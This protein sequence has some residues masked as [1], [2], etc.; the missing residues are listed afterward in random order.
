MLEWERCGDLQCTTAVA[1]LDWSDPGSG[2]IELALVRQAARGERLGSLL[3]NPGG[4][5]GRASTSSPTRSTSRPAIGSS[6]A[7]TWSGSTRAASAG[8]AR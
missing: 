1:P 3:V 5:G 7:S 2:E 8:P 4:P 6:S